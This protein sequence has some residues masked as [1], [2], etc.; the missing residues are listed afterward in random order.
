MQKIRE[1]LLYEYIGAIAIG[2]MLAQAAGYVITGLIQLLTFYFES[3]NSA[4][5]GFGPTRHF[6]WEVSVL[7][8]LVG[9]FL[10]LLV[11]YLLLRWL[12]FAKEPT[13]PAEEASS[14]AASEMDEAS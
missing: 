13:T 14:T 5:T 2:F 3:R 4:L 8:S 11:A 7:P 9:A 1:I 6:S 10:L 12:Y